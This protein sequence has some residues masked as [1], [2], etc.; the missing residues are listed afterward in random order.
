MDLPLNYYVI[1]IKN[2]QIIKIKNL[3]TLLTDITLNE[4]N[5]TQKSVY[6]MIP[7]N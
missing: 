3:V 4:I 2:I 7:L 6:C 1:Y 5:Y